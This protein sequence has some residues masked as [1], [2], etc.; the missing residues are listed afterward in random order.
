MVLVSNLENKIR[1]V[2]GFSVK[3]YWPDGTDVRGDYRGAKSY[4]WHI[5][6]DDNW[7]IAQWVHSRFKEAN[8]QFKVEVLDGNGNIIRPWNIK[9]K[10]VRDT[11]I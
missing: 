5:R 6:S 8:P 10:T 4:K 7:T 3:V 2:E 1:N 11:Y 9:L